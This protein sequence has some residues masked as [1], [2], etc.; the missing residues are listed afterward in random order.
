MEIVDLIARN[1]G[2]DRHLVRQ[3][4]ARLPESR[5][6][7]FGAWCVNT[8]VQDRR[9]YGRAAGE[10]GGFVLPFWRARPWRTSWLTV[11]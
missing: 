3:R 9:A 5:F 7:F 2:R 11:G 10:Q 6:G 8:G 1:V 4:R